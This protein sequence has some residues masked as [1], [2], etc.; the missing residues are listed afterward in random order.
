MAKTVGVQALAWAAVGRKRAVL[1]GVS[2][3]QHWEPTLRVT[4]LTYLCIRG[5]DIPCGVTRLGHRFPRL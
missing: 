4:G 2:P 1:A 5:F 3:P